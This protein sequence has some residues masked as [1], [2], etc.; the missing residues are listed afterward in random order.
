MEIKCIIIDD[1]PLA[2]DILKSYCKEVSGVNLIHTFQNPV[3][4][5][6]FLSREKVDLV[7]LDIEMP[8]LSGL[9]F[10]GSIR[11]KPQIIFTTAYPQY[12]LDGFELNALDYLV[13]PISFTRFLRAI[14]KALEIRSGKIS[15]KTMIDPNDL[16]K[17]DFIFVKSEYELIK[18]FISE[19][20]YIEG[21]KDYLKIVVS[22][23]KSILTLMSFKELLDKLP[24]N[25][26]LRVH[27]SY[28]VNLHAVSSI[29]RKKILIDDQRIPIG[30]SYKNIVYSHLNL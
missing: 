4:A 28:A 30:E 14:H 15:P 25:Q 26:F 6:A 7:F 13:K 27:R 21:L 10:V 20:K 3:D 9:E 23:R 2:I 19:I 8:Q 17:P 16:S 5:L 1:E 18:L 12:A 29:Q 11:E 22:N 24:P